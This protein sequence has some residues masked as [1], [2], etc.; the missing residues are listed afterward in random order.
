MDMVLVICGGR[1]EQMDRQEAINFYMEGTLSCEGSEQSRYA[2]ILAQLLEGSI[3]C[4]D[5]M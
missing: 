5:E 1:Q 3:V 2:S 4:S